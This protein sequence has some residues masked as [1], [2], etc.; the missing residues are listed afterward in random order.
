MANP[1]AGDFEKKIGGT[2]FGT[3]FGIIFGTIWQTIFGYFCNVFS[4][5]KK[6]IDIISSIFQVMK[7]MTNLP[8]GDLEKI[9]FFKQYLVQFSV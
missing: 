1:S 3:I 7:F 8:S 5:F 2:I 6:N 4:L 9:I